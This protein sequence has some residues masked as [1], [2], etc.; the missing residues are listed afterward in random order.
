MVPPTDLEAL[1]ALANRAAY[2]SRNSAADL[3]GSPHIHHARLR[4]R[5]ADLAADVFRRARAHVGEPAVLDL[6]AGDGLVTQTFLELGARVTAV[7]VSQRQLAALA[8]T[9]A[10][11]AERLTTECGEAGEILARLRREWRRF[12][13]VV[14]VS[15][16]HHV[17]DYLSIL[18]GAIEVVERHGQVFVFQDPMWASSMTH[19]D[20]L[21]SRIAYGAWRLRQP[22]ALGGLARHV[23][24]RRGVWLDD[25]AADNV[26]F[27]ELRAGVDQESV[28]ALLE[29]HGFEVRLV[30]Y[31]STQSLLWQRIGD[32]L[33]A[34]NKFA[35]IAARNPPAR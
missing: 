31:F 26:E 8:E 7:D 13:V 24:R 6:G 25:C 2:D 28:R 35:I 18:G 9:T 1:A 21:L 32:R 20:R 16:L 10:E 33:R 23:R 5:Y 3:E 19:R 15:F 34:C 12:D 11:Y 4:A 22:D 17:P 27:H 30:R 29:A 14:A